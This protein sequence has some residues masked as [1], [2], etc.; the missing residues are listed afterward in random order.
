MLSPKYLSPR[1]L[2]ETCT[3][4]AQGICCGLC[5]KISARLILLI[6]VNYDQR[7]MSKNNLLTR[8][9]VWELLMGLFLELQLH[10]KVQEVILLLLS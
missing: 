2:S 8:I 3:S 5:I 1:D 6:V 7:E 4:C 10:F 9:S